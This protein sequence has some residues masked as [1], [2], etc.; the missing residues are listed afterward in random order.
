MVGVLDVDLVRLRMSNSCRY[1]ELTLQLNDFEVG[2]CTATM[3]YE[4][5]CAAS[6]SSLAIVP[7]NRAK[8]CKSLK[9][10]V[11]QPR[12]CDHTAIAF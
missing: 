12:I 8:L 2:M 5:E 11:R 4:A 3:S 10:A 9:R 6:L 7:D 1:V